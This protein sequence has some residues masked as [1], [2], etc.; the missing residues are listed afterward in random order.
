M[1]RALR[2]ARWRPSMNEFKLKYCEILSFQTFIGG[3]KIICLKLENMTMPIWFSGFWGLLNLIR[4]FCPYIKKNT[5]IFWLMSIRIQ[6]RLKIQFFQFSVHFTTNRI[7]SL[8]ETT[9]NRSSVFREHHWKIF[10][11]LKI[12]IRTQKSSFWRAIIDQIK[13][14]SMLRAN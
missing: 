2:K 11:S 6:T 3:I 5:N 1:T 9:N 7:F 13:K 10:W 8:L 4:K 12:I 14:F